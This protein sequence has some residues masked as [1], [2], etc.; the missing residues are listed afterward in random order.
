MP[1][2]ILAVLFVAPCLAAALT[3][4][5]AR[6]VNDD[7]VAARAGA[8]ASGVLWGERV[9]TTRAQLT[10]WLNARG[11]RYSRWSKRHPVAARALR[12]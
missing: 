12:S 10:T 3:F 8:G 7:P 11:A 5:A 6:G 1:W 4:G 2:R 9:F